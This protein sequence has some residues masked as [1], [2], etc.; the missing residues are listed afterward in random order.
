M[1][2]FTKRTEA[3]GV[4]EFD[5]APCDL[6]NVVNG[7]RIAQPAAALTAPSGPFTYLIA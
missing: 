7:E 3:R 1:A 5:A 4:G 2:P 6:V